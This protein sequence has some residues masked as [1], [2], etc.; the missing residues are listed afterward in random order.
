MGLDQNESLV[1]HHWNYFLAL[2]SDM[3][4]M[5]RYIEF[6]EQNYQVY[7]IEL[8]HLLFAAASEFEV[9][10]KALCKIIAPTIAIRRSNTIGHLGEI[11][12]TNFPHI[13]D[14]NV[15]INRYALKLNT[16]LELFG[17]DTCP[18][19]WQ[20]YNKVKHQRHEKFQEATLKNTLLALAALSIM[21]L[22]Q[23]MAELNLP[24]IAA[25]K[26]LDKMKPTA[27]LFEFHPDRYKTLRT[28]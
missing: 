2:E 6:N 5:A 7:S 13:V 12:T 18:K 24:L 9:A 1:N 19:W 11:I 14:E 25:D 20:S 4:R 17:K 21:I 10:A 3:E 28:F 8:A 15:Y 23:K 22:Y 27:I 26:A 16:P